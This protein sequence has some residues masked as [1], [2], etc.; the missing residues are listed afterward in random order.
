MPVH[1]SWFRKRFGRKPGTVAEPSRNLPGNDFRKFKHTGT[2]PETSRYSFPTTGFSS[3]HFREFPLRILAQKSRAGN[4]L[5]T[6]LE[7]WA[8]RAMRSSGID[9][10]KRGWRYHQVFEVWTVPGAQ[11]DHIRSHL[12]SSNRQRFT[13]RAGSPNPLA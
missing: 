10:S 13:H 1:A 6:L 7:Q 4:F 12:G 11:T 8:R 5:G 2:I 9:D 3:E